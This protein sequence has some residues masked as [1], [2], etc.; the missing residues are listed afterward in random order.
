MLEWIR[1]SLAR[2]EANRAVVEVGGVGIRVEI[3][4]ATADALGEPGDDVTLLVS[5]AIQEAEPKVRLYGFATEG[6][7]ALFEALR[8]VSGVGAALALKILT[9]MPAPDLAAA[10]AAGDTARLA[11]IKGLGEKRADV[12]VA[13]LRRKIPKDP[14]LG[15]LAE[16]ASGAPIAA[17]ATRRG[18]RGK[19]ARAADA[20][21]EIQRSGLGEAAQDTVKAL[22]KMELDPDDALVLVERAARSLGPEA[23]ATDLLRESL[24]TR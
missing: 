13:K 16:Q 3:P 7:R 11:T 10:L 14:L 15:P 19:A 22:V 9:G 17:G 6:E 23:T 12:L 24:R 5:L 20:N 18:R 8:G 2:L 21:A 4:E 1:G